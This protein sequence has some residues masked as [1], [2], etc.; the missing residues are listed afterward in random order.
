VGNDLWNHKMFLRHGD[1]KYIDLLERI[2]YN[3]ALSGVSLAGNTFFY[4]NPLESN[5]RAKRTEY[6]EVACCPANLARLLEQVP[7]LVYAQT[8][9]VIYAN[10]YV[11]NHAT[12]TL[13][14]RAV[15]IVE[16]TRYPWDG[17]VSLT[18]EPEGSGAFTVALRIPGWAR[19][20]PVPSDLYT[21][22]D[23]GGETASLSV[24]GRNAEPE[25]VPLDV[26]DGYVRIWRNWKRGDT[27]H[28]TLPMPA[29]RVV[30]HALVREDEAKAAIQRGPLVYAVE[31]IDNG[32]TALDLVIPRDA[33]LRARFRADLLN[34]VDVIT[35]EGNRPFTAVPYYAW[36]NRGQGEMAVWIPNGHS[37]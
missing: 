32:G 14:K 24:R 33:A 20:Q 16:D 22:A 1:G 35:G 28:L 23:T 5:G 11:G 34:G 7:G 9:D 26:R 30:A 25:R 3:G 13:G 18:L 12:V 17:D 31:A 2:L 36:N 19:D 10:L 37:R 29:R 27:I 8:D 4:Q 15:K 21:F 6:F